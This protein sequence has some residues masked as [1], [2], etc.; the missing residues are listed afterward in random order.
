MRTPSK[1]KPAPAAAQQASRKRLPGAKQ[2]VKPR[3]AN[4]AGFDQWRHDNIGRLLNNAVRRFEDRV[5][6]LM[7]DS[8]YADARISHVNLTRNLDREGTRLTELATRAGMTKQAMGE[9]VDQCA[10]IG[11]VERTSDPADKRARI[12]QFT[13]QGLAW[14]DAFRRAVDQ[15]EHEMRADLGSTRH[16]TVRNALKMYGS[17]HDTLTK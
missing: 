6:R 1:R 14:L 4:S 2:E 11:L 3:T 16:D 10:G 9:L 13:P 8:G 12:V 15:A 7:A 5:L 17:D